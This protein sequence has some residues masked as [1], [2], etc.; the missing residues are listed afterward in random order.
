MNWT[1]F[2]RNGSILNSLVF[3]NEDTQLD[4]SFFELQIVSEHEWLPI[5]HI[6]YIVLEFH[7]K[8]IHGKL[9]DNII[10]PFYLHKKFRPTNYYYET[11][12]SLH[13]RLGWMTDSYVLH[14]LCTT[15]FAW[16]FLRIK[17]ERL[18]FSWFVY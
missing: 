16:V 11:Y 17:T 5:K 14:T 13:T 18:E 9:S 7:R 3:Q 1:E 10:I 8:N 2:E 15:K 12:Y 6:D 4:N